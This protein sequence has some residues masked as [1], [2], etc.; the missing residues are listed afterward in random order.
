MFKKI[1][2]LLLCVLIL[3][4]SSIYFFYRYYKKSSPEVMTGELSSE[5]PCSPSRKDGKGTAVVTPVDEIVV[6]SWGSWKIIYTAGEEGIDT[7]GGVVV[8]VSPFWGWTVPQNRYPGLPGYTTVSCSS[9]HTQLE[10][11]THE[12]HYIMVRVKESPLRAGDTITIV[13]G[14]TQD[15]KNP[16]ARARADRYAE[17]DEEFLVKVDGDG[18]EFFVEIAEQPH[19]TISAGEPGTLIITAPS[20]VETDTPFTITVA[21][22]DQLDNWAKTYQGKVYFSSSRNGVTLPDAYR[23]TPGDEGSR[24]F[25]CIITQEGLFHLKVNDRD[26]GFTATSNPVLSKRGPLPQHLYW[27]DIHGHANL[28]DG[29]GTPDDY[30]Q[31]AKKVAA[32]DICV[33]TDHDAHGLRAMDEHQEMWNLVREKSTEYY[34]KGEFVTFLGY[35]WTSWT[36]GHQHVIF[37]HSEE[38]ELV[39]FRDPKGVSPD[40]LWATLKGKEVITIPHHVGGGPIESDWNYYNA[41]FQPLTEICSVHGTCEFFGSFRGIYSP[42]EGHFVQDALARGY[43]LGIIASGDSHNGH[44]GRK[45]ADTLTGGLV[46][47]YAEALDRKSIWQAFKDRRVYATSGARIILDFHLNGYPTGSTAHYTDKNA[48][49]DIVGE[50]IG[51]EAMREIVIIKNGFTLHTTPGQGIRNTIHHRDNTAPREGDYYYLRAVQEDGEMA[52]SSPIWVEGSHDFK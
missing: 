9:P 23:F 33:L 13:Y 19:L 11:T 5:T 51:T 39:S 37:L 52:W 48:T 30:Y 8:Q 45:G 7:G 4:V 49:R 20:I 35:E 26:H 50:V 14:D 41:D 28:C 29:S 24:T 40:K 22:L 46:G 38:G 3:T 6:N 1:F 43:K 12:L 2:L 16:Q 34:K 36:Y 25:N 32:L 47:V 17:H 27:G 10:V 31:Y 18:D 21:A 42:K 15:G 44:P